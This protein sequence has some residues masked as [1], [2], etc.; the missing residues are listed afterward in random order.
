MGGSRERE[1]WL[2]SG[3]DCLFQ[4]ALL[5]VLFHC[6][7]WPSNTTVVKSIKPFLGTLYPNRLLNIEGSQFLSL[8]LSLLFIAIALQ[9]PLS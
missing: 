5:K 6:P 3:F 7:A 9:W 8:S 4:N 2:C 1:K